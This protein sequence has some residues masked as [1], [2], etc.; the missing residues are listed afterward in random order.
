MKQFS[1]PHT[2]NQKLFNVSLNCSRVTGNGARMLL[3]KGRQNGRQF[4]IFEFTWKLLITWNEQNNKRNHL[5]KTQS[6]YQFSLKN[7]VLKFLKLKFH[8]G[9]HFFIY[10]VTSK[11]FYIKE[12]C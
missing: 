11:L 3:N 9:H 5:A 6:P 8:N 2:I 4:F 7:Y 12:M 10:E 1:T